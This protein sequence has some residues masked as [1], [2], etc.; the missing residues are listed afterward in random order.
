MAGKYKFLLF[1]V[2]LCLGIFLSSSRNSAAQ[3]DSFKLRVEVDLVTIEVFALDKGGKPVRNLKKED[4]RLYEDGK[5]QEI[6]SF[7]CVESDSSPSSM[8]LIDRGERRQGKTV[9]ILFN[10]S[11]TPPIYLKTSRDSAARFVREHMR[12]G[13]LFAVA[14]FESLMKILQNLTDDRED[15]LA[16]IEQTA[17][18]QPS[19]AMYFEELLLSLEKINYSIAPLKGQKSVLIY[20]RM[21][22]FF[23]ATL[24]DVYNRVLN[25]ANKFNVIY[26]T[27]DPT[28]TTGGTPGEFAPQNSPPTG[29]ARVPAPTILASQPSMTTPQSGGGLIPVTLR[30]LANESGGLSI[31]DTNNIDADLDKLDQQI[32]NYYILGFQSSNPKHDGAFRQIKIKTEARGATLKHRPG[33]QDRRPVDVLASSKQE[34]TLLSA[35]ASP[36]AATQLPLLF[37][38]A[39]FY[40]SPRSARV[41]ITARIRTEK[42]AFKK[43]GRQLGTD[44]NIMGAAY[45]EDGGIAARFSETLP[46]RFEKEKEAEFRNESVSYHNYF[47]LRPGRY[48]LKLAASDSSSSLGSMEQSLEIPAF[49]ENGFTVS[50][51]IVAEKMSKLPDLIQNLQ[52]Q[53]LDQSDLLA[54]SGIQVQPGVENKLPLNAAIPVLFRIYNLPGRVDEWDLVANVALVGEKGEKFALSPI[55]L[56]ELLTPVAPSEAVVAMRLPFQNMPPGKYRLVIETSD[57]GSSQTAVLQ[58]DLEVVE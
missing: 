24:S 22:T 31:I 20:G 41:L 38:P 52:T 13:D 11:S 44:L 30:S 12:P 42:M 53:L 2:W 32:S 36:G 57:P 5:E 18:S 1:F 47:K 54:C 50:S 21:E 16:A 35:L 10:D 8:P 29:I 34:R 17:T 25:S 40:D 19:G 55:R 3:S 23:G 33:Y 6:L 58:T 27:V 39:Y 46:I 14:S 9:L 45:A 37:R 49:P 51:L 26:Y 4:F 48:R 15:V 43:K 28:T 56:K 7:D